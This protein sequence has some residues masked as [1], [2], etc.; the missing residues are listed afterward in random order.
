MACKTP[1]FIFTS[2]Y[3]QNMRRLSSK[4]FND[5]YTPELES[6]R[7]LAYGTSYAPVREW[8]SN[9]FADQRI[10]ER[11]ME[12]PIDLNSAKNRKYYPAHPQIRALT[13]TLRN[14][15]LFRDEHRDFND[16]MK[17]IQMAK[18]KVFRQRRGPNEK[19]NKK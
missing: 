6:P 18:G 19:K 13:H 11:N 12:L 17:K 2:K 9:W 16:E 14:F 15:G 10:V 8:A 5:F 3:T 1:V 4:I 7:D